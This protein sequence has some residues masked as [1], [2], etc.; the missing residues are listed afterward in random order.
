MPITLPL[1][2]LEMVTSSSAQRVP[3]TSM[4]RWTSATV[5]GRRI[6]GT[7]GGVV[8]FLASPWRS[9]AERQRSR[10]SIGTMEIS[11]RRFCMLILT[12]RFWIFQY[13]HRHGKE[14]TDHMAHSD[15]PRKRGG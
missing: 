4:A 8:G 10:H 3:L 12:G 2:L 15:A 7:G 6:T 1:T 13:M 5:A 14:Q 11:R 9:Q